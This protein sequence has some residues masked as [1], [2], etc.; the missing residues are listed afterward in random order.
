MMRA[1]D[2]DSGFRAVVDGYVRGML[3]VGPQH[4]YVLFYRSDK[5]LGGFADHPNVKEVLL[6]GHNKLW[7]DQVS[8]PWQARREKVDVLFNPK[9]SV[10]LISHCPVTMGLQEPVWYAWPQHYPWFNTFYMKLLL[11]LYV[12]KA[13]Y[14]FPNSQFILDENRKFLKRPFANTKIA[15]S[16]T[17]EQF[18]PIDDRAALEDF[19]ARLHLPQHYILNVTRV[20][21]PGLDHANSFHGGK[22]P[23]TALRAFMQ[24]RDRVPHH[25]VIAGRQVHEYLMHLGFKN[26][27]L[28]RVRLIEWVPFEDLAKL[29]NLADLFVIPSFYEGCPNTLMQAMACGRPIV[30]SK[31][32]GCPDIGGEAVLFADPHDPA[33]FARQMLRALEDESLRHDLAA[34]SL[35]R[36]AHFDWD[37]TARLILEGLEQTV[38][39]CGSHGHCHQSL[40]QS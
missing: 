8:V 13:A 2:Q 23:E 4:Q 19:R 14:F 27:D 11:P 3:R 21:H 17:H 32:G 5:Y 9:F 35:K 6:T 26:S 34:R 25:L 20:T 31:T 16:A 12:R 38:H 36:S 1:M 10:P 15:Y 18:Q 28:E 22:N 37:R 7:W 39:G 33:D 29:Y 24:I 40:H 30:A